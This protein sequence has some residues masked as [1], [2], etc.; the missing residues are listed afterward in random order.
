M[1]SHKIIEV[2]KYR[3]ST[4]H[5][6]KTDAEFLISKIVD[7]VKFEFNV[8]IETTDSVKWIAATN[9]EIKPLSS[10]C[11]MPFPLCYLEVPNLGIVLADQFVNGEIKVTLF[12]NYRQGWGIYPPK[13]NLFLD[14]KNKKLISKSDNFT[15]RGE[16]ESIADKL[17]VFSFLL[18]KGLSALNCSNVV[19]VDNEPSEP[20]NKKRIKNGKVPLFTYKTLHIDSNEVKI[21]KPDQGGTHASP[22]V[23]LRRGHVRHYATHSVWIEDMIVGDPSKGAVIK[24]YLVT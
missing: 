20:L 16:F 11:K 8:E 21:I 23:H 7:S 2:V 18:M 19:Y 10:E 14:L 22:R 17:S 3:N 1:I 24:D 6:A 4:G 5:I 9:D 12:L 13:Y 15:L